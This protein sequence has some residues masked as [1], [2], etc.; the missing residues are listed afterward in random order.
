MT[1][2]IL[3]LCA[4]VCLAAGSSFA[5][6][7]SASVT[8]RVTDPSTSAIAGATVTAKDLDRGTVWTSKT[9]EEGIYA[10]PRI[11]AGE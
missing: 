7:V 8:G 11:P 6:E 10:F 3:P 4:A 2:R 1:T 5:Q 9:N